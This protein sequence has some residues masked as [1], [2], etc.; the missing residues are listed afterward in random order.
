MK[1]YEMNLADKSVTVRNLK[2]LDRIEGGGIREIR[3]SVE[4]VKQNTRAMVKQQEEYWKNLSD[5]GVISAVEKQGLLREME[6]IHQSYAA[7]TQQATSFGYTN[8][9][10]QDYANTY[11]ALHSYLYDTLK[12]FDDMTSDTPVDDRDYFNTLFSNYFFLENFILLAISKGVLD[13]ISIRVLESLNES[14]EEGET[15][16][17][18][19]GLYQYVD[20]RWK[21]VTT[22]DYKGARSELPAA[23]ENSYFLC[24]ETFVQTD[25]LIVNGEEL[26]V[27]NDQLGIMHSYYKGYIYY[28]MDGIWYVEE[29]KN[30]W[31]YA[32][33]FADVINVTGELPQ[34]FQDGLDNLQAQIDDKISQY[35]GASA[36]IPLN[37]HKGDYFTY[38]GGNLDPWYKGKVYR[39]DGEEWDE[40]NP[41]TTAYRNY[42]MNAL[43]DIL[44]SEVTGTGYFSTIFANA[45][46]ANDATLQSLSTRTIYLREG[47]YIQ[48][49]ESQYVPGELGLNIDNAG[50]IDANGNTHIGGVCTIDGTTTISGNTTI[51][52]V[53][54]VDKLHFNRVY[55]PSD[56]GFVDGDIWMVEA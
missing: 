27:N 1:T 46:F 8:P 4:A 43:T 18:L 10:M 53:C 38:I 55:S 9:I 26:Y 35:L 29:D 11:N 24:S 28:A 54:N 33:A 3:N 14:G 44:A 45:F 42:Y 19:G 39:W 49:D 17:Y 36:T 21:S 7:V 32:A 34:I 25:V 37:P 23:A 47:G 40:L 52:G 12:L 56:T 15:A 51:A 2:V 22:G 20:G 41:N 13:S 50:N 5:D 16:I 31:R 48:S 6:N 30:N